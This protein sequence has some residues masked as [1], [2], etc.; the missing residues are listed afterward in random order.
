[1]STVT[2]LEG[3]LREEESNAFLLSLVSG[4]I[5]Q[6]ILRIAISAWLT[7]QKEERGKIS[8]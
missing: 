2:T 6:T 5:P 3:W 8:C 1:M 7:Q 4:V